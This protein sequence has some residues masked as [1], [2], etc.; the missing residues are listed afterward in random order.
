VAAAAGLLALLPLAGLNGVVAAPP[1]LLW[2]VW[3][4]GAP[5]RRSGAGLAL[6]AV[7]GAIVVGLLI[8]ALRLVGGAPLDATSAARTAMQFVATGLGVPAARHAGLVGAALAAVFACCVPALAA[9]LRARGR[10][11]NEVVGLLALLSGGLGLALVVGVGRSDHGPRAGLQHRYAVMSLLIVHAVYFA[12]IVAGRTR[13]WARGLQWAALAAG[14]A[15]LAVAT[16]DGIRQGRHLGRTLADAERKIPVLPDDVLAAELQTVLHG[17]DA[18]VLEHRIGLLRA[19]GLLPRATLPPPE[20]L[21]RYRI[22]LAHR[23]IAAGR[24]ADAE[25]QIAV[26]EEQGHPREA[27]RLRELLAQRRPSD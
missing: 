25:R 4:L 17:G 18:G 3:L 19:V 2:V 27:A 1:L 9:G 5:E 8:D 15:A 26:L 21:V 10:E 13:A 20:Q 7:A 12:V 11:R 6:V 24:P 14:V 16:A 23:L 22:S